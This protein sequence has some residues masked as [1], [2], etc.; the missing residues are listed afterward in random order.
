MKV[1]FQFID[2]LAGLKHFMKSVEKM[3]DIAVDL[4]ADSMYHFQEKVCL[5]QVATINDSFVIDPIRIKDMSPLKPLFASRKIKKIFHGAD[6]DVRS[7]Y[8]DFNIKINNLF[9]TQVACMF[10]GYKETGLNA[11]LQQKFNIRL[12]TIRIPA[13]D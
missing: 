9:D 4:E 6:Y 2:T 12:I 7:L 5:I 3:T 8:R 10:L 13:N 11:V 1:H